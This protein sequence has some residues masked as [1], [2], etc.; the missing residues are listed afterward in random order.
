MEEKQLTFEM[1]D[2]HIARMEKLLK[3]FKTPNIKNEYIGAD[4]LYADILRTYLQVNKNELPDFDLVD[5]N[6]MV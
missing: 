3:K 2:Q 1:D 6:D 5:F 4:R